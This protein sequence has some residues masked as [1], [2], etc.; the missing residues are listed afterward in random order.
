MEQYSE[1]LDEPLSDSCMKHRH[2]FEKINTMK[3]NQ[4]TGNSHL[5]YGTVNVSLSKHSV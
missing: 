5:L 4:S 3:C 1:K 2:W